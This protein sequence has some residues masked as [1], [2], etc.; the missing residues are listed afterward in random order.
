MPDEQLMDLEGDAPAIPPVPAATPPA[1]VATAPAPPAEPPPV[2][3]DAEEVVV[4]GKQYAPVGAL[5]AERKERQALQQKAA[6]LEQAFAEVKPYA[7]FLKANP[8]FLK[9]KAEPVT[10]PPDPSAE[11]RALEIAKQLDFYRAD[12]TPDT[13]RGAAHLKLVREEAAAITAETMRPW[14]QQTFEQ[15]SAAN[16][17]NALRIQDRDGQSPSIESLKQVWA[18]QGVEATADERVA[19]ILAATAMGLDRLVG[20]RP[21]APPANPPLET[22]P[23]G[24][25]PRGRPAALTHLEETIASRRGIAPTKWGDLT[26]GHHPGRTSLLED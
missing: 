1:P 2:E 3:P 6:A 4:G 17:Q 20:K 22:E 25:T 10:P 13:A 18:T 21:V 8:D 11:P 16:F 23:S 19:A 26:K 12:G 24:G 5:I 7:D 14:Q 15:R 9:P